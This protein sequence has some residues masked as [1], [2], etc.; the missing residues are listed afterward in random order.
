MLNTIRAVKNITARMK[1]TTRPFQ[2]GTWDLRR[3]A[4]LDHWTTTSPVLNQIGANP[5]GYIPGTYGGYDKNNNSNI[6]M[7]SGYGPPSAANIV[8][9]KIYQ[10]I[11]YS[12]YDTR[13]S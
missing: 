13:Y 1:N 9:G 12:K 4:I 5:N 6:C 7:Q 2:S 3:W 11:R 8:N 10:T